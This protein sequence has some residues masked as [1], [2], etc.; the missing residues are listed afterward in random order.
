MQANGTKLEQFD[1]FALMAKAM[2]M[3]PLGHEAMELRQPNG[4]VRERPAAEGAPRR[5]GG[6]S[7]S[8]TGSGSTS[9]GSGSVSRQVDGH[10]R[11]PRQRSATSSAESFIAI[12]DG[13]ARGAAGFEVCAC[14]E[15]EN[16]MTSYLD[17]RY[18]PH[19]LPRHGAPWSRVRPLVA[20]RFRWRERCR[21]RP[22][23][24]CRR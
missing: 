4:R 3:Q 23:H 8:I 7:A 14:I 12:T 22:G 15:K 20:R 11:P 17:R 13:G 18:A 16:T 1:V 6:S 24:A 19:P 2:S 5:R 10:L 21:N 9:S